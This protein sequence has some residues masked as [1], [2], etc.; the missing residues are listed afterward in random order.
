MND[1]PLELYEQITRALPIL[2]VDIV[3]TN[4][5]GQ[6]LLVKRS[7]PP[8]QYEWWVVG[9]RV[10][11]GEPLADA[12]RRKLREEVGVEAADVEAV[13]YFETTR[14]ANP[15][16]LPFEYHAVSVVFRADIASAQSVTLDDQSSEWKWGDALPHDFHIVPFAEP[17]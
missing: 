9:G 6:Y 1:I 2:C 5:N 7:N 16:G 3:I 13:G 8:K 11:K 17:K 12:A 4:K 15:F 10:L 14:D